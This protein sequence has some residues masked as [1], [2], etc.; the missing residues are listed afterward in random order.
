M[1]RNA[2][3][4]LAHGWISGSQGHRQTRVI[5]EQQLTFKEVESLSGQSIQPKSELR[6]ERQSSGKVVL[7]LQSI[8]KQPP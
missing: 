5:S 6:T 4:D 1:D 7:H 2:K 8:D 3:A